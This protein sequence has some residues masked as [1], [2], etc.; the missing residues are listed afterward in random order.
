MFDDDLYGGATGSSWRGAT[1]NLLTLALLEDVAAVLAQH[2][3]HRYVATAWPS[4]QP[5]CT[6]SN[7]PTTDRQRLQ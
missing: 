2:G 1:P 5:A 7:R 4:S 6:G 3:F